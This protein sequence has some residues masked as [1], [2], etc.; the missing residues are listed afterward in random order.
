M[1][2]PNYA[3]IYFPVHG[4]AE[5]IRLLLASLGLPYTEREV[6]RDTWM[7]V[8]PTL[9][10]GQAPVLVEIDAS[11]HETMVPQS[12]AILRHLG[13]R[14][15]AYGATEAEQLRA[16]VVAETVHDVRAVLAPQLAPGVRG[17]DPAALRAT[18]TEKLPPGLARLELLHGQGQGDLFVGAR[19]TWADC[20][21]F[22]LLDSLQTVSPTALEAFPGL[23]RFVAAMR[24]SPGL[25]TYLETR[26]PSELLPLRRVV[27]TGEALA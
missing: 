18:L 21:A 25:A 15:G 6:T 13:R 2:Q 16:D 19:P 10:L 27:E 20:L 17:K 11:G 7:S 24:A 23:S 26:R 4:R 1:S 3:L 12:Q 8:R 22:D 5:P 9:P 14:H